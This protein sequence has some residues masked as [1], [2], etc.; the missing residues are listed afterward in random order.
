MHVGCVAQARQTV[1]C[2]ACFRGGP[3][4][5]SPAPSRSQR[6]K[7][8]PRI[9]LMSSGSWYLMKNNTGYPPVNQSVASFAADLQQLEAVVRQAAAEV[10]GLRLPLRRSTGGM[11]SSKLPACPH[12]RTPACQSAAT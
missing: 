5:P 3:P 2:A 9:I 12:A 11:A 8:I 4:R 1:R 7:A 10:G 6:S